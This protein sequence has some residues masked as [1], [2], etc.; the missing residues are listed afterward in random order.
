VDKEALKKQVDE[1]LRARY[2][3]AERMPAAQVEHYV[4]AAEQAVRDKDPLSAANAL[5][6]ASQLAPD[7]EA[8]RERLAQA[9][10]KA[11]ADLADTYLE[12]A[13]YEEREGRHLKAAQSYER[14]ALGKR[15]PTLYEHAASCLLEGGGE[16]KR[17]AELAKKAVELAPD[18]P[19][20]HV[21]LSRVYA[22]AK[23]FTSATTE[24]EKAVK[25]APEN[26]SAKKWL[27]RV[28]RGEI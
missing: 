19:G 25:L 10:E 21:T 15:S 23:M 4:K 14:A 17:A 18:H 9:Q 16:L 11:A 7:D 22:A 20:Y 13:K 8:L 27:K 6:I 5:R 12:Q 24:A 28:K 3:K 1:E 2:E 26:E